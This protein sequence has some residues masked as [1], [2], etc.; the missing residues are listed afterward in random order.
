MPSRRSGLDIAS[1]TL[2]GNLTGPPADLE[3]LARHFAVCSLSGSFPAL[4]CRFQGGHLLTLFRS[5]AVLA[6]AP[7]REQA[8]RLADSHLSRLEAL[9]L[10]RGP[11][12]LRP[13]GV[14]AVADLHR[15]FDLRGARPSLPGCRFDV[16]SPALRCCL[17]VP[18]GVARA[19]L[20]A[21]GRVTMRCPGTG[22]GAEEA[23]CRLR[24]MLR[25]APKRR[26]PA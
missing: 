5:G 19:Q 1:C 18:G 21:S 16:E 6:V 12:Q 4:R 7:T 20:F 26:R 14:F 17:Q 25:D 22:A 11:W 13:A 9:G 10:V 23:L 2:A 8:Q 24:G 15:D 3:V